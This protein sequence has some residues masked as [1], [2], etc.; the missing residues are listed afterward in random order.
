MCW[1]CMLPRM[2][3]CRV[4]RFRHGMPQNPSRCAAVA[5]SDPQLAS[6]RAG[7]ELIGRQRYARRARSP[8]TPSHH[9]HPLQSRESAC[10]PD[11]AGQRHWLCPTYF[12][13]CI[14]TYVTTKSR[15]TGLGLAV[16]KKIA[17]EHGARIELGNRLAPL[18]ID[19]DLH[20]HTDTQT[21]KTLT[22]LVIGAQVSLSFPVV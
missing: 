16:V 3:L 19:A 6:K 2:R 9:S 17:D 11:C 14:R 15:G 5:S 13:A 20:L 8:R 4:A 12:A 18:P 21:E 10:A 22:S 7:C 1:A